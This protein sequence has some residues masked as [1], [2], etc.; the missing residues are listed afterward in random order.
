M[1]VGLGVGGGPVQL[2]QAPVQLGLHVVHGVALYDE[3]VLQVVRQ[4][5]ARVADVDGRLW[6]NGGAGFSEERLGCFGGTEG[7]W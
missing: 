4:Q 2:V 6:R 7:D 3:H 1:L 5:L